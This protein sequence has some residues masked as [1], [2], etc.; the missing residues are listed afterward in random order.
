MISPGALF[1]RMVA[2]LA[3]AYAGVEL[4][5]FEMWPALAGSWFILSLFGYRRNDRLSIDCTCDR[6]RLSVVPDRQQRV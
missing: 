6:R 3:G 1:L 4:L 5:G 2:L